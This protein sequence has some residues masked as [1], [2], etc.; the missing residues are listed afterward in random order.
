MF[1]QDHSFIPILLNICEPGPA[2]ACQLLQKEIV[3]PSAQFDVVV[4]A[5]LFCNALNAGVDWLE[6]EKT[7]SLVWNSFIN[8]LLEH[9][10]DLSGMNRRDLKDDLCELPLSTAPMCAFQGYGRLSLKLMDTRDSVQSTIPLRLNDAIARF[11]CP[12]LSALMYYVAYHKYDKGES[13]W[14]R[15][16]WAISGSQLPV[17]NVPSDT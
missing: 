11:M 13:D 15:H 6:I 12:S 9:H 3:R 7:D 10:P 8:L 4:W 17:V 1:G 2:F 5:Q 16:C 14:V